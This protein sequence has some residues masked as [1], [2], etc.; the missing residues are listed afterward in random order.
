MLYTTNILPD[1]DSLGDREDNIS[2]EKHEFWPD[3]WVIVF[4]DGEQVQNR[5]VSIL[6]NFVA[7]YENSIS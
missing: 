2:L 3:W 1:G 6:K 4:S 5:L 7:I